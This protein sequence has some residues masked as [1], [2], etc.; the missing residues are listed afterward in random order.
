MSQRPEASAAA[1]SARPPISDQDVKL[2]TDVENDFKEFAKGLEVYLKEHAKRLC[3]YAE[4]S[5]RPKKLGSYVEKIVR[6]RMETPGKY[7][8]PL[9]DMTDLC[10]ARIIVHTRGEVQ[11]IGAWIRQNFFVDDENSVDVRSRLRADQFGYRSVHY[12][13]QI[14]EGKPGDAR[15]APFAGRKAEIQ[16]RTLAQHAWADICHDR[17]YKATYK[18]PELWQRVSARMAALLESVDDGFDQLVGGL[19]AYHRAGSASGPKAEA[20]GKEQAVLDLVWKFGGQHHELAVRRAR[21]ALALGSWD[22]AIAA[23]MA[24][25]A[26]PELTFCHGYALCKKH[27]QI[28]AEF[29][30]GITLMAEAEEHDRA[31]PE[32]PSKRGEVLELLRSDDALPAYAEGF[33]RDPSYPAALSGYIR[34]QIKKHG[35]GLIPLLRPS[36]EAAIQ[37]CRDWVAAEVDLPH[38]WYRIAGF[39]A[40]LGPEHEIESLE[41]LAAAV[42]AT[43]GDGTEAILNTA[44]QATESVVDAY[45]GINMDAPRHIECARRFLIAARCAKV[46]ESTV[47]RAAAEALATPG[48][49]PLK[50]PVVIVAGGCAPSRQAEMEGYRELLSLAFRDFTGTIISGGTEQGICGIVGEIA[51]AGKGRLQAIGYVPASLPSDGSATL[52]HRYAVCHRIAK[53]S[54]FS[55]LEPIQSWLDL[56]AEGVNPG[57]VRLLGINGG[58]IAAFEY[59]MALA[60]GAK[61]AVVEGSGRQAQQLADSTE[62]ALARRALVLPVDSAAVWAFVQTG[63]NGP[64][65]DIER[66][67]EGVH[68]HFCEHIKPESSQPWE[69]LKD[70]FK[71]ANRSQARFAA[72]ILASQGYKL[73]PASDPGSIRQPVFKPGEIET[74]ARLEHGRWLLERIQSGWRYGPKRDNA[75]MIHPSLVP[76]NELSREDQEKDCNA[77]GTWSEVF[78]TVGLEIV[79]AAGTK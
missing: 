34:H 46:P 8:N 56:L 62:P 66:A 57:E 75:A 79:R 12:V 7:P 36:I 19:D 3:P 32:Y 71:Q 10:G 27:P 16:V 24:V 63:R 41:A 17:I 55:P 44:L 15:L 23:A 39:L 65:F 50:R 5:A 22:E 48:R 18:V 72:L 25:E 49:T 6:K 64:A 29:A 1:A 59:R 11:A 74:M 54:G 26:T 76:W 53:A 45:T 69:T 78:A 2:F 60:L 37:R 20:L 4:V 14:R 38:A 68:K 30:E 31:N 58:A 73:R 52:D 47:A 61:V 33:R 13:V 40:L 9:T 21:V 67:A 70:D 28:C 43:R 35:P 51:Q 42:D 77:V